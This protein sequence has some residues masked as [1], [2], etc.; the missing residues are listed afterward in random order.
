M[1]KQMNTIRKKTKILFIIFDSSS[2]LLTGFLAQHLGHLSFVA[3]L[4][5][6][7]EHFAIIKII[8][9]YRLVLN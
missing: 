9:N 8:Y 2:E 1:I 6:H 7:F 4:K 5:S 3:Y